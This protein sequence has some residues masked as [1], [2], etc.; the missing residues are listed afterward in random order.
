MTSKNK[1]K[2]TKSPTYV[3]KLGSV[4]S[5]RSICATVVVQ[6]CSSL[7]FNTILEKPSG[8]GVKKF[9]QIIW[10]FIMVNI[11][12]GVLKLLTAGFTWTNGLCP[13]AQCPMYVP[14]TFECTIIHIIQTVWRV[15]SVG[16]SEVR[17]RGYTVVLYWFWGVCN[18]DA[19]ARFSVTPECALRVFFI[20]TIGTSL[21]QSKCITQMLPKVPALFE[22]I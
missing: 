1:N 7:E 19:G 6:M 12:N 8:L 16:Q 4:G 20:W 22:G 15:Q 21:D 3:D 18:N 11:Y 2:H 14:I 17:F 5:W 9:L 13:V 10:W